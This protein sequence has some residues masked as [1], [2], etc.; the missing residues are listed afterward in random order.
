MPERR[1][2]TRGV[3]LMGGKRIKICFGHGKF[4]PPVRNRSGDL[5]AI[6]YARLGMP[7]WLSWLRVPLLILA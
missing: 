2:P 6:K 3:N 1:K 7:G 4:E 5:G